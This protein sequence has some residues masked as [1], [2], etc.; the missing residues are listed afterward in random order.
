M[1][2][3][4]DEVR[5]ERIKKIN[6]LKEKGVNP[7]P[8]HT[9]RDH[10]IEDIRKNF[11]VFAEDKR[12]V[13]LAGRVMAL[14]GQGGLLFFN[15]NDGTGVFQGLFKKDEIDETVFQMFAETVDIGDFIE[16]SGT[17]FTTKRGEQTIQT[18]T[19][20]MLSKSL[21]PLPDKWHGLQDT[22]ERYRKRYLDILMAPEVRERFI[23]RSKFVAA[24][25]DFLNTAEFMEV[26][27]PILQPV[28]GGATAKPFK[29][30]H[31]ALDIGMYLRIAPELYLKELLV[32]GYPKVYELGRLFRN[33]G[34]DVTHNPEFTTVEFYEAY[35]D[36]DKHMAFVERML[37][38]AAER[39]TGTLK[40]PCGDDIIDFEKPFETVSYFSLFEK[41]AGIPNAEKLTFSEL[42]AKAKELKV[43]MVKGDGIEKILDNIYKKYCRTKIVQPTYVVDYPAAFSPLAKRR[44]TDPGMIERYQLLIG[45]L[46]V[47]NGFSELNDPLDQRA[48]FVEQEAKRTEGDEEAQ[49]K[50]EEYLEAMEHGMPPAGGC[51]ISIDR[52]VMLLTDT[53]N[54]RE[55]ILFPTLRPKN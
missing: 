43:D 36:A 45:G 11:D 55:V 21:R 33:E 37:R 2:S 9:D 50:D 42:V 35:A 28:A 18:T 7:Y 46:E 39:S 32:A 6:A 48:R 3:F 51:G 38:S 41:Y 27:T 31:Q 29:T 13:V 10:T 14:R 23:I 4:L 34:I 40:V 8:V 54:V 24:M 49:V 52:M 16:V 26:E 15:L 17:L 53:K 44:E 12:T 5:D 25:R 30:H 1:S 22:E 47:L 19:W 20:K